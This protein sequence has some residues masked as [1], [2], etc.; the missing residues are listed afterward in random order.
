MKILKEHIKKSE[1][2]NVY[3]F[4][5]EESYLIKAYE[6]IMK[7]NIIDKGMEMMNLDIVESKDIEVNRII[8]MADTSP[9]MSEKRLI[10]VRNSGLFVSGKKDET[11]K[12]SKY[13]D[14]LV[15]STIIIFTESEIDKR[16]KLYKKVGERGYVCEFKSPTERE[17]AEW[18]GKLFKKEGILISNNITT[19]ILGIVDNDMENIESEVKKLILYKMN[20]KEVTL[21]DVQTICTRSVESKIFDLVDAVGNKDSKVALNIFSNLIMMKQSPIMVISMLARQFRLLLECLE[22]K[23]RGVSDSEIA[24]KMGQKS[25]IVRKI[26]KQ[27]A[28]FTKSKLIDALKDCLNSDTV[29]KTG[30]MSDTLAVEVLIIKY[31]A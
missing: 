12:M 19:A 21:D 16:S 24:H 18:I 26:S 3:L 28:N 4:F 2:K 8:D 13:L 14:K 15:D 5:G 25:F 30:K 7:E 29:I 27:C 17:M 11:E 20:E 1:Y 22:L 23:E 10:I 31:S 6:N 9:F